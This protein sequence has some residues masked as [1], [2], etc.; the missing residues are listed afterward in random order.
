MMRDIQLLTSDFRILKNQEN[1]EIGEISL[2]TPTPVQII[3]HDTY[4]RFQGIE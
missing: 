2:A 3:R 4:Q 1:T